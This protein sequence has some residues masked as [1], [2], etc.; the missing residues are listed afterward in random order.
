M[1]KIVIIILRAGIKFEAA[2]SVQTMT[3]MELCFFE[4]RWKFDIIWEEDSCFFG[5]GW[6][7]FI[8]KCKVQVGDTVVL[9][10]SLETGR[11]T[12]NTVIFK[13]RAESHNA[14]GGIMIYSTE[15]CFLFSFRP[16]RWL[17]F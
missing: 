13:K 9:F 5:T 16:Y 6:L 15:C 8:L 10:H 11:T 1:Y 7:K 17:L 12:L 14:S 4:N 2:M 3:Y